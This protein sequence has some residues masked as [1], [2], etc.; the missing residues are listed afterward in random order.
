MSTDDPRARQFQ[1]EQLLRASL[2]AL[3][4]MLD[5]FAAQGGDV[6]QVAGCV[7]DRRGEPGPAEE[8]AGGGVEA[9]LLPREQARKVALQAAPEHAHLLDD[10][11]PVGRFRVVVVFA[12]TGAVVE[13]RLPGARPDGEA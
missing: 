6:S 12:G 2:V 13:L 9:L 4:E 5:E 1:L 3:Q 11:A 8:P 10:P 7:V